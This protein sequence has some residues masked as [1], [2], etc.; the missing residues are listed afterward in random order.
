M[1]CSN[2]IVNEPQRLITNRFAATVVG[3]YLNELFDTATITNNKTYFHAKKQYM[4]AEVVP[5]EN[6]N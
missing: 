3:G 4:R 5:K 2:I 6:L 1:S